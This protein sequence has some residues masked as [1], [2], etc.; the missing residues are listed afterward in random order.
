MS[1]PKKVQV[2]KVS[3]HYFQKNSTMIKN[4]L[5]EQQIQFKVIYDYKENKSLKIELKATT[6]SR[7][8]CLKLHLLQMSGILLFTG[9]QELLR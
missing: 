8:Q 9:I 4:A 6:S 1:E 7:K 5:F 2:S 3:K